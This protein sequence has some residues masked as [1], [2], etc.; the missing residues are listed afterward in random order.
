M[1]ENV[2]WSRAWSAQRTRGSSAVS[3]G[4]RERAGMLEEETGG[5]NRAGQR[6]LV[7]HVA[8]HLGGK[9]LKNLKK[10]GDRVSFAQCTDNT[11]LCSVD[12]GLQGEKLDPRRPD[13]RQLQ[14]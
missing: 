5:V 8:D 3:G 7:C 9:P 14:I 1:E 2:A 6:R 11:L 10:G 13:G 4:Q 12:D